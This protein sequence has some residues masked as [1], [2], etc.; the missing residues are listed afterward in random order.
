MNG[1]RDYRGVRQIG[2]W[3]WLPKYGDRRRHRSRLRRS[4]GARPHG[5]SCVL[6]DVRFVDG[7]LPRD[8]WLFVRRCTTSTAHAKC[9]PQAATS[10][11]VSTGRKTGRRRDGRR[12]SRTPRTAATAHGNQTARHQQNQRSLYRPV[13]ARSATNQPVEPPQYHCHLRLRPHSRRNFLLRDGISR[14]HGS[15]KA[16]GPL[17]PYARGASHSHPFASLRFAFRS[18]F[19]RTRASRYQA[20]K[21]HALP[22]G[23]NDRLC[24]TSRLRFGQGF[25]C[26]TRSDAD[27]H[28]FNY[29]HAHVHLAGRYRASN[30]RRFAKRLICGRRRRVLLA[31]GQTAV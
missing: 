13:R 14:R 22:T 23:R 28:Q 29:R 7:S 6:D 30:G 5:G 1:H 26:R 4:H 12:L 8:P 2:A 11:A 27:G 3:T 16:S 24:Q 9:R 25:G 20:G 19:A 31:D 17:W 21:C 18:A 15:R 10:G